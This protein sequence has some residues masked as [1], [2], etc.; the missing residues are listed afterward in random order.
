MMYDCRKRHRA[1]IPSFTDSL[2]YSGEEGFVIGSEVL[3]IVAKLWRNEEDARHLCKKFSDA[4]AIL[5]DR[6]PKNTGFIF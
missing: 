6:K 2:I 5:Y 1:S 4:V 3:F